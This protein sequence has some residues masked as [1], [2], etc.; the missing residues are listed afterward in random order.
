MSTSISGIGGSS[1]MMHGARQRPD[2]EKMAEELFAKLDTSAQGYLSKSDLQS[3]LDKVSASSSSSS[4]SSSS[5]DTLFSQLDT[6]G[7]GKV[8]K[9][10]FTDT[11][12]KVA[13][14]LDD[15]A[16]RSRMSAGMPPPPPPPDGDGG[17][18][19][20]TKEQLTSQLSEIGSSDSTR[21]ALLTKIV[22]NF[23][24]ADTN[25]DGKVSFQEA[26]AYDQ[27]TST[28][29]TSASTTTSSASSATDSA[30]SA[31]SADLERTVAMQIMKL[32]QAYNIGNGE[33]GGSLL[34]TLSALA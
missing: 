7:D 9:Q 34:S 25:S 4:S 18:S 32:M 6:D 26:M 27:S 8:T 2:R 11:L 23:D 16:M 17:D 12:K 19:G 28:A 5:V 20:F 1:G 30:S 21:S 3:A 24:Q 22:E 14:Q 31:A 10:E 15:Q 33:G 29:S 13:E